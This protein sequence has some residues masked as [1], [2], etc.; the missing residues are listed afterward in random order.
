MTDSRLWYG[1]PLEEGCHPKR[2]WWTRHTHYQF[3]GAP[4]VRAWRHR[5]GH[6]AFGDD[7]EEIMDKFDRENPIARP[8]IVVGQVWVV[9]EE[10]HTPEG[11]TFLVTRTDPTE[12][13]VG[14]SGQ[15]KLSDFETMAL[16]SG[17]GAPWKY[18]GE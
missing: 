10:T 16:V 14:Y 7:A 9:V 11:S 17:Y 12:P 4:P 6:V 2:P 1:F 13:D 18:T 8:P 3:K 15:R 5:H